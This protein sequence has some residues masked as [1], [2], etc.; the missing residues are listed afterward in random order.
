MKKD[1]LS[2]DSFYS[3]SV[4]ENN[5]TSSKYLRASLIENDTEES[6]KIKLIY[7]CLS[8]LFFL[9]ASAISKYI[10]INNGA[11]FDSIVFHRGIWGVIFSIYFLQKEKVSLSNE[12]NKNKD[13]I[14][15][16]I[17]RCFLSDL[18]H[19]LSH[20][21]SLILIFPLRILFG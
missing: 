6:D 21:L 15:F 5:N 20:Y 18:A 3:F 16:L 12:Y 1:L 19:I 4:I 2:Q 14:I 8:M 17:L 9:I 10:M 13:K 7:R 11:S